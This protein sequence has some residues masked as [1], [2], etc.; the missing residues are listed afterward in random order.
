MLIIWRSKA[1]KWI[2]ES[3]IR[4]PYP[5]S[6]VPEGLT[7]PPYLLIWTVQHSHKSQPIVGERVCTRSPFTQNIFFSPYSHYDYIVVF[8]SPSQMHTHGHD[9]HAQPLMY[10]AWL[11]Y[12]RHS[13]SDSRGSLTG[14]VPHH[15]HR[16]YPPPSLY[17]PTN[18]PVS[19]HYSPDTT[20]SLTVGSTRH[21]NLPSC[22][23]LR[24]HPHSVPASPSQCRPQPLLSSHVP[25]H[26][27]LERR[28]GKRW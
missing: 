19:V 11:S 8:L 7:L 13:P 12:R 24:L 25:P 26:A 9:C 21:F 2:H 14:G 28:R 1:T 6:T 5:R 18:M 20:A 22:C 23:F 27:V 15:S 3:P 17:V 4:W 16:P 10:S